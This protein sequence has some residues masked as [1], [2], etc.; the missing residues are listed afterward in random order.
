MFPDLFH[1][2]ACRIG[3]QTAVAIIITINILTFALYGWDKMM[4]RHG[5]RRVRERTL[6]GA[7]VSGGAAGALLGMRIFRHKTRHLK[8][9]ISVPLA[10]L[11]QA[12]MLLLWLTYGPN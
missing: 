9:R 5:R 12:G 11:V 4:A 3:M 6:I 10:L 1:I 2:L 8:F 7:A